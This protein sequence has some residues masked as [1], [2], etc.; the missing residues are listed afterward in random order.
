MRLMRLEIA[1]N[2]NYLYQRKIPPKEVNINYEQ[3]GSGTNSNEQS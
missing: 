3:S 1:W 2:V